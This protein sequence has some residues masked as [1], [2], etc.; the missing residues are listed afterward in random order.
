MAYVDNICQGLLLCE[1]RSRRRAG[2]TYWI[3]DERPYTMNEIIDTVERVLE[4]DFGL[5]V[6]HKRMTLP[7]FASDVA[8]LGRR[9]LQGVGLYHQKIHVLSEMNK[10]IACTIEKAKR[11]LGYAPT[12]ALEE[13]MR[14]SIRWLLGLQRR[15]SILMAELAPRHRRRR[16]LRQL[17]VERLLAAGQ[18]ACASS[19]SHDAD[20]RRAA[21]SSCAATSATRR[22]VE[23]ACEGVDVV[24]PQRRAG[25]AREGQGAPSSSV[26]DGGTQNL[27]EAARKARRAQ[28][29]PHVV[30]R[31][32]RRARTQP[33]RPRTRAPAPERGLR[34]R[35]ARRRAALP[36]V[37]AERGLDVTDHPP[38]HDPRPRPPRHLADPLRVDRGTGSNVPVLGRGRQPLPV[39]PRRRPRRRRVPRRRRAARRRDLQRRRGEVRHDAR[40]ARGA[41][42]RHAAPG[43]ASSRVPSAPGGR[44][45]EGS[46][47]GSASRRSAPYHALMY[48]RVDVLRHDS[49]TKRELGWSAKFSNAEMF[50]ESYDW[51]VEHRDEV[52]GRRGASHHRS[53]VRQGALRAV[54]W[55]L[56]LARPVGVPRR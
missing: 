11:E 5:A 55:T 40:D 46:R 29:R 15:A 34:P 21:S 45:D 31:G 52:L 17:L 22:A 33:G 36:R 12:V 1:R 50:C 42:A 38:A 16:L 13:G 39:R 44:D 32:L 20:G 47:A 24:A 43:A 25:A 53:P 56:A 8:W 41:R 7:G 28:G 18:A 6:A 37:R 54:S 14:R 49:R 48:G 51:Y 23:R 3:A 35:Q 19:T 10:T 26:N 9:L 4:K 30:E 2:E 27:L